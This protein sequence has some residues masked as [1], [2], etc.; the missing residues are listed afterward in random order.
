LLF[1]SVF[2]V[3][4]GELSRIAFMV[5]VVE[6]VDTRQL[7]AYRFKSGFCEDQSVSINSFVM[8]QSS[9]I[10]ASTSIRPTRS[11]SCH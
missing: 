6:I 3:F 7:A 11:L 5:R 2:F 8:V 10:S 1:K 9:L 4:E